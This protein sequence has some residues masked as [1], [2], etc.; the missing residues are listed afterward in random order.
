ML[1]V[2]ISLNAL[3]DLS[4]RLTLHVVDLVDVTWMLDVG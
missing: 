4:E 2:L 3:S 1:K